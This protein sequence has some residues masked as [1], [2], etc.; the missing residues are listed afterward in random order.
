MPER[1][2]LNVKRRRHQ[3]EKKKKKE[4]DGKGTTFHR[5]KTVAISIHLSHPREITPRDAI[6][7]S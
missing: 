5:K 4:K 7:L 2:V 6:P 3:K 1:L